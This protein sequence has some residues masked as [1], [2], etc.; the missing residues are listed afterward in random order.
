MHSVMPS[1]S[2]DLADY[3]SKGSTIYRSCVVRKGSCDETSHL[4][5]LFQMKQT[6]MDLS[7]LTMEKTHQ[8]NLTPEEAE[9]ANF[10]EQ[11]RVVERSDFLGWLQKNFNP[12]TMCGRV[13]FLLRCCMMLYK[14]RNNF[15]YCDPV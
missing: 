1:T 10:L 14:Q 13:E 6:P 5:I 7:P 4:T 9:Q 15:E 2:C 8:D 12:E 3:E 11:L